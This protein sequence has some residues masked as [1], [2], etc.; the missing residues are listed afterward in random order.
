M[1]A[2]AVPAT[3][4]CDRT[5]CET[6]LSEYGIVGMLDDDADGAED[7]Q[8]SKSTP[9]VNRGLYSG[10]NRVFSY[11]LAKYSAAELAQS[12]IACGWAILFACKWLCERRGN[13]APASLVS[14]CQEAIEQMKAIAAGEAILPDAAPYATSLPSHGNV[15]IDRNYP[16]GKVRVIRK[17]SD[18]TPP[19]HAQRRDYPSEYYPY[20]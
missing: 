20:Q 4:L 12:P 10:T 16:F 19:D 6:K 9:W 13:P 17:E 8:G 7:T 14:E 15:R 5:D 3:V 2:A 11:L 1:A 18:A